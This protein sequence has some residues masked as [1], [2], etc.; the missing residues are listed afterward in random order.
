MRSITIDQKSIE[1]VSA[2]QLDL[3]AIVTDL[4]IPESSER[5]KCVRVGD[6][7]YI[8]SRTFHA[9]DGLLTI[10]LEPEGPLTALSS[11]VRQETLARLLRC[12]TMIFT[13]A[14]AFYSCFMAAVSSQE[15][16]GLPSGSE[17]AGRWED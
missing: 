7:G 8:L 3:D 10:S 1:L 6:H 4:D 11:D 14:H 2:G 12:A 16:D 5:A 13:G 15:P 9:G 17:D